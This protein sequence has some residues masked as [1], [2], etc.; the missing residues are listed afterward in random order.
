MKKINKYFAFFFIFFSSLVITG[1]TAG[2]EDMNTNPRTIGVLT[3]DQLLFRAQAETL[4]AGQAWN[5]IYDA[6]L[7]WMQYTLATW[8]M[9]DASTFINKWAHRGGVGSSQYGE[10]NSMG[11]YVTTIEVLAERDPAYSNIAQM[12]RLT[13]IAKAIHVSDMY[14]SLVYTEGWLARKGMVDEESMNPVFDTQEQLVAIWDRELKEIIQ[15]LQNG[16]ND[17]NQVAARGND[18]AYAG[19]VQQWIKAANGIRLRLASRLWNIQPATA[20]AIAAEVLA[21]S[22]AANVFSGVNDNF[23]FWHDDFFYGGDW[24]SVHDMNA[25]SAVFMDYL[26]KNEDP[27]KRF[28]FRQNNLTRERAIEHNLFILGGTSS[29]FN[30][31]P[32][33]YGRWVGGN[34]GLDQRGASVPPASAALTPPPRRGDFPA[35]EAGYEQFKEVA[36]EYMENFDWREEEYRYDRR[37]F[38]GGVAAARPANLPQARLWRGNLTIDGATANGGSCMLVMTFADF[39]F[40]A[41]EFVLREGIPSTRTAQQWYETGVR[42]SL[43]TWNE[44]GRFSTLVGFT[45]MTEDEITTFLNMPDVKWDPS[46]GLQQIYVQSYVEHFKNTNESYALWKRTD[47]FDMVAPIITFQKPTAGGTPL[48]IPRRMRFAYPAQG[49]ANYENQMRRIQDMEKDPKFGRIDNE[50]GRIWWDAPG[51]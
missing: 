5:N 34:I 29:P 43:D 13:L 31:V 6:K 28:Y 3:A 39:C 51:N 21:P 25:A 48:I 50:W 18:R 37:W 24:H 10:F 22:N 47:F 40:L 30:M 46:K 32:L 19:N 15:N 23:A 35:G 8:G 27:R 17:P 45:A 26:V 4:L 9:G 36:I 20:K 14:G 41:A 38:A 42:A 1:C 2:F 7:P 12:A 33:Y 11:A 44:I 49:T 16:L